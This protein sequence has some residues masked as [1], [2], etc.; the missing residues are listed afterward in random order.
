MARKPDTVARERLLE[1]ALR[2]YHQDGFDGV[3]MEDVARAAKIKKANLFHYFPSKRALM[4]AVLDRVIEGLREVV[5]ARFGSTGNDPVATVDEMFAETAAWMSQTKCRGGCF[6]GN[7]ALAVSDRDEEIRGRVAQ[8]FRFWR[9]T[10]AGFLWNW[11]ERGYFRAEF[12]ANRAAQSLVS[13]L[14]GAI[15]VSKASRSADAVEGA[16]DMARKYLEMHKVR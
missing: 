6:V 13:L 16:R 3:S 15:L 2:L 5:L 8:H 9:L 11:K 12:D 1:T 14:E 10:I 7:T 4:Q